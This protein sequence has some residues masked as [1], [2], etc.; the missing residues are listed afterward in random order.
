MQN[1]ILLCVSLG[2]IDD[3]DFAIWVQVW[4]ERKLHPT[5]SPFHTDPSFPSFAPSYLAHLFLSFSPILHLPTQDLMVGKAFPEGRK[6]AKSSDGGGTN[7]S[8][9]LLPNL[10]SLRKLPLAH[11]LTFHYFRAENGIIASFLPSGDE[12]ANNGTGSWSC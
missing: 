9:K 6:D 8:F 5:P 11:S 1:H 10:V 12:E 4:R 7:S 2:E 3:F